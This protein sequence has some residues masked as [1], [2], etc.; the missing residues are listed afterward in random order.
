MQAIHHFL[1]AGSIIPEMNV[2]D[3]YAVSAKF[4]QGGLD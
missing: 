2:E 1:N 4:L 3:V